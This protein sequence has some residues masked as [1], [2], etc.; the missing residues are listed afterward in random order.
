MA[1][2]PHDYYSENYEEGAAPVPRPKGRRAMP[3][4]KALMMLGSFVVAGVLL[5]AVVVMMFGNLLNAG[6]GGKSSLVPPASTPV[7]GPVSVASVPGMTVIEQEKPVVDPAAWN[8]IIVGPS[9]PIESS[10]VPGDLPTIAQNGVLYY[11]DG[12]IVEAVQQMIIDCNQAGNNLQIALGYRSYRR[13]NDLY[14]VHYSDYKGRGLS[15]EDAA[16][17]V[18]EM[19]ILP[20]GMSEH[21]TGLAV[22]FTVGTA[23]PDASF[24]STAEFAWLQQHAAEY[25]FILR[26]PAGKEAVTGMPY[27]PFH[28]RYVGVDEAAAINAAGITL[29]EY[30]GQS[31]PPVSE[32]ESVSEAAA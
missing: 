23:L 15:D 9:R 19:D 20:A 8:L 28:F 12:R 24:A 27:H 32:P 25:G 11:F 5:V 30:V 31:A 3:D 26:Y 13:Q 7:S 14:N 21:Q 4:K 2:E 17:R 1:R 6:A 16:A 18:R 22:D 10:F 29:E